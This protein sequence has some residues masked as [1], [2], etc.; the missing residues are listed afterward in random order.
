[1]L[2]FRLETGLY[3]LGLELGK[4][5]KLAIG[6]SIGKGTPLRFCTLRFVLFLFVVL[7]LESIT[8]LRYW[9][10]RVHLCFGLLSNDIII[11]PI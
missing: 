2:L 3:F 4:F 10:E 8:V 7:E 5:T 9:T 11:R 1:M 6:D